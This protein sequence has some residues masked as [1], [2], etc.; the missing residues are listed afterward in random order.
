MVSIF[1]VAGTTGHVIGH[2]SIGDE[3]VRRIYRL[4]MRQRGATLG[5]VFLHKNMGA[6]LGPT[7]FG[8]QFDVAGQALDMP[9]GPIHEDALPLFP[10]IDRATYDSIFVS[11]EVA[12][13]DMFI[14]YADENKY[15][16]LD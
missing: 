15:E 11:V 7:I 2:A 3:K 10:D 4:M 6:T 8:Y 14:E 9:G 13:V 1:E 5:S 12:S 16:Y